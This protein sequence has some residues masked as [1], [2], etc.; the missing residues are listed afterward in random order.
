MAPFENVLFRSTDSGRS[1][2]APEALDLSGDQIVDTPSQIIELDNGDWF[3][4]CERWKTWDDRNDLPSA[5]HPEK[6]FSH[7]RYTKMRDG[8]ICVLQWAQSIGAAENFDLHFSRSD[9][10]GREWTE[11]SPTGINAQTSWVADL[12][13]GLL[14]EVLKL[15]ISS[16]T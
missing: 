5:G 9:P 15:V 14:A 7:S 16:R 4:A 6:M 13:D 2:S 11:P 3:L 12:G 8:G 10:T 1:W